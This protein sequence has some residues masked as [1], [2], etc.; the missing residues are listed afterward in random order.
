MLSQL[1]IDFNPKCISFFPIFYFL[2][3]GYLFGNW[4]FSMFFFF[5]CPF[6]Y[7]L[8]FW[9]WGYL[10]ASVFLLS[11]HLHCFPRFLIQVSL[12]LFLF[13]LF[14]FFLLFL[15]CLDLCFISQF[16]FI[17]FLVDWFCYLMDDLISISICLR[18]CC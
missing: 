5:T 17:V 2:F 12:L 16:W 8:C 4:F 6:F 15:R 1:L 10:F 3:L 18:L 11:M 9:F 13:S 7:N 14:S